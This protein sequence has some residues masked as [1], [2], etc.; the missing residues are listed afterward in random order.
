MNKY[1]Y[2]YIY[3]GTASDCC[4]SLTR[5]IYLVIPYWKWSHIEGTCLFCLVHGGFCIRW[6]TSSAIRLLLNYICNYNFAFSLWKN[7]YE[8]LWFPLVLTALNRLWATRK[9]KIKKKH[10]IKIGNSE[11][12]KR[13]EKRELFYDTIIDDNEGTTL[14]KVVCTQAHPSWRE[15]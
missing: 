8:L 3:I 9:L 11:K 4:W 1:I 6:W 13:G 12:K 7:G 14:T 5:L 15:G 10:P 2:I